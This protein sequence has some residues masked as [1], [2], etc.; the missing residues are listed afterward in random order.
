MHSWHRLRLTQQSLQLL[1]AEI[2]HTNS[3]RLALFHKRFH[4]F[5]GI[6]VVRVAGLDL[7]AVLG[8]ELGRAC[9]GG[10]PVHEVEIW[11]RLVLGCDCD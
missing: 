9:E 2:A 8:H 10:G 6:H 3:L 11:Y 7:V 1:L 4:G 5:P